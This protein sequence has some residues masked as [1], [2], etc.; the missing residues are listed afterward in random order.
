M[1]LIVPSP[2]KLICFF[3]FADYDVKWIDKRE[4][5]VKL[6]CQKKN[7]RSFASFFFNMDN[8]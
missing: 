1:I 5:Q 6:L 7:L 4:F 3:L 8:K 2:A